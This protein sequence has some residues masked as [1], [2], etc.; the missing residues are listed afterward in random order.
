MYVRR[1]LLDDSDEFERYYAV[2]RA[3]DQ[4]GRERPATPSLE[5]A[6]G[7][8]TRDVSTDVFE[9]FSGFDGDALVCAGYTNFSTT[10]NLDIVSVHVST[11]PR[12]RGRGY[13]SEMLAHLL[14]RGRELGR[15]TIVS[16]AWIPADQRADHPYLRFAAS[17]GFTVANIEVRRLL[18]LPVSTEQIAA[19][20]R[21]SAPHHADY[22][23][24]TCSGDVPADLVPSLCQVM[25]QLGV[26]APTGELELEPRAITPEVFTARERRAAAADKLMLRALAISEAGQ[27]VGFTTLAVPMHEP[28]VVYQ[29]GTLVLR[30]HRGHRLGMAMKAA[31]LHAVQEQF[32][33][34]S[35][36]DTLNAEQNQPMVEIN[37]M[38]GFRP[39]ELRPVFR[40][41]ITDNDTE[42][43]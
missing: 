42:I 17:N 7:L 4:L 3:A 43:H 25:N 33:E 39:V 20:S 8:F 26:E 32:P 23:V 29:Y 27:V 41:V 11:D 31:S 38:I 5:E 28:D 34:R 16:R 10:D 40:R 19:W 24:L 2:W 13:G 18:D 9:A 6:R 35:Y 12:R 15:R 37:E 21:A 1:L 30:D 22:R 14:Q 36:V